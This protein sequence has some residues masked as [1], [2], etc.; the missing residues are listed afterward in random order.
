MSLIPTKNEEF[1][2]YLEMF[3]LIGISESKE[4]IF[5]GESYKMW[6]MLKYIALPKNSTENLIVFFTVALDFF[7][8]I[9]IKNPRY[10]NSIE[11]LTKFLFSIFFNIQ[12]PQ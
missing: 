9:P 11:F 8:L 7:S 5:G 12:K 2:V 10:I 3:E 6:Q 1:A 4:E